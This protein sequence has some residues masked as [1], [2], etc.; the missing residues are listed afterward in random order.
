VNKVLLVNMPF[1]YTNVPTLGISL[2]REA[3]RKQNIPCD[4][5]YLQF[6]FAAQ[7][8]E[9]LYRR[10]TDCFP[11]LLVGE[12]LFAD[13][14][15]G[16]QLPEPQ[17]YVDHILRQYVTAHGRSTAEDIISHLPRIRNLTG[18][19]LDACISAVPWDQYDIVGFTSA[20]AQNLASLAL[21][22]RIKDAWPNKIIVF[23]GAN[24]EGE[25]GAEQHRQ[26]PFI[27]YICSGE[28]DWLFPELVLR[29]GS[30]RSIEDLP[31]LVYRS[32]GKTVANGNHATPIQNLDS[33]PYPNFD[34]F[35]TQLEESGLNIKPVDMRLLFESGRGCWWGAKSQC[36]FCGLNG[37]TLAFRRKSCSRILD[38]FTFLAQRY[39]KIK[40]VTVVDNIMDFR[41]FQEVIPGLI[42]RNLGISFW[43]ETKSNL[44]KEQIQQLKLAKIEA[45]Q[46]GIESLD[47]EV[48]RLMNKGCT[49]VQNLQTLKWAREFGIYAGWNLI[50]GFP[51]EDPASY[52]RMADMIPALVHLQ[53]PEYG[54]VSRLRLDRFSP[55]FR[56]PE[57]YG[58]VNVKPAAAYGYVYPFPEDSLARLAY[59]FDF[60]YR[61]KRRPETYTDRLNE[62]VKHWHAQAHS[63]TLLSLSTD[64]RLVI[65]DTRV[66]A[67][68]RETVLTGIAKAIYEF[69]DEGQTLQSILRYLQTLGEPIQSEADPASVQSL[70][71]SLEASRILLHVDDRYLSLAIPIR[72]RARQSIEEF[73]ASISPG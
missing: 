70:L 43:Y 12:W 51:G 69:C 32:N 60:D 34:D 39:P 71:A 4:I 9:A 36:T 72:G 40:G 1:S 64:S 24:Y 3:V 45:V 15:F 61:D 41:Y 50:T 17:L 54:E 21:A 53:P 27:D 59:H 42:E 14:L 46:A 25:M 13:E 58:M 30:G 65:Y 5:R 7:V 20:F 73:V 52:Q 19:Y 10:I 26:F 57:A 8:G 62:A 35:F 2:L 37:S 38:E 67:Q 56:E 68:Q 31:G 66:T 28:A 63:G 44:R 22:K 48:L 47:S 55:Y 16:D 6:A 29:L 18:P 49:T 33:L 11:S 23:G